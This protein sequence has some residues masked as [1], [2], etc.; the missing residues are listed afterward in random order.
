MPDILMTRIYEETIDDITLVQY[1]DGN[2]A[3]RPSKYFLQDHP[4]YKNM[5]PL[6]IIGDNS[7][8]N[9]MMWLIRSWPYT[10]Y[11]WTDG[12]DTGNGVERHA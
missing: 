3:I 10:R 8:F 4:E 2:L 11:M 7:I 6:E 12:V 1:P 5:P 9:L